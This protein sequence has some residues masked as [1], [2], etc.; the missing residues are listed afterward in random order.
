MDELR[1]LSERVLESL[2]ILNCNDPKE[3]D[4]KFILVTIRKHHKIGH[5]MMLGNI[6]R[7]LYRLEMESFFE[8]TIITCNFEDLLREIELCQIQSVISP[9]SENS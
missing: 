7:E 2:R 1:I 9:K 5:S 3:K 8:D 6:A 4:L